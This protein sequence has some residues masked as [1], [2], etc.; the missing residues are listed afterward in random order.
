MAVK[1]AVFLLPIELQTVLPRLFKG[2]P[3][4]ASLRSM[5]SP[6]A[7][8]TDTKVGQG[9]RDG[10]WASTTWRLF[11]EGLN[12]LIRATI[13]GLS[14]NKFSMDPLLSLQLT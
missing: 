6:A 10:L 14:R 13:V 4:N 1:R 8:L 3:S 5:W 9:V 2:E 11:M 7:S 12:A